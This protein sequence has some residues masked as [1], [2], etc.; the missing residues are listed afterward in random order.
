[1]SSPRSRT[2]PRVELYCR[3]DETAQ[4]IVRETRSRLRDLATTDALDGVDL[5]TWPATVDLGG[6]RGSVLEERTPAWPK[7]VERFRSWADSADVDLGAA[8][9]YREYESPLLKASGRSLRLPT[10]AAAV[11]RDEQLI[12]VVPHQRDG[13]TV[14]PR[15][16]LATLESGDLFAPESPLAIAESDTTDDLAV[17]R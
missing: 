8:F 9:D 5:E 7:L 10:L 16:L 12:T 6:A 1:M 14:G 4:G 2:E 15:D 11:Y 13:V 17:T 3:G